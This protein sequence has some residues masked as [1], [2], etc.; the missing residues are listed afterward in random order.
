VLCR[1]YSHGAAAD[2]KGDSATFRS[3]KYSMTFDRP[4]QRAGFRNVRVHAAS[5]RK[6]AATAPAYHFR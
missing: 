5:S 6:L 1:D 2:G 3:V 4:D